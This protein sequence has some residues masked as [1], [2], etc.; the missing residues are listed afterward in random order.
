M[1][2]YQFSLLTACYFISN[3]FRYMEY[4]IYYI[5]LCTMSSNNQHIIYREYKNLFIISVY[6]N[7]CIIPCKSKPWISDQ[8]EPT[9]LYFC[10]TDLIFHTIF[11]LYSIA[12]SVKHLSLVVSYST[13]HCFMFQSPREKKTVSRYK[14]H[15]KERRSPKLLSSHQYFFCP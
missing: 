13:C 12:T 5:K 6:F 1:A 3:N 2:F 15:G 14:R 4:G 9:L 10:A 7:I 8:K 11:I